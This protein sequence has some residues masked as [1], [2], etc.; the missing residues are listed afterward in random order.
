[1]ICG[2]AGALGLGPRLNNT[3]WSGFGGACQTEN[4]GDPVV[5]YDQM[6]DR[7][8]L[9]QFTSGGPTYYNCVALSTTADPTGSYYRWAFTTGTNFPDYPKYGMWPDA[10]YIST[11][12]FAGSNF[13]GV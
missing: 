7:W 8:L 13:A 6:A 9:T 3:L 11:R 2:S 12:E 4:A 10:Y 1:P 5:E